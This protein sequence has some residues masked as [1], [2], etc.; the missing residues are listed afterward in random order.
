MIS[1]TAF[2]LSFAKELLLEIDEVK[3]KINNAA[4]L[5]TGS[6]NLEKYSNPFLGVAI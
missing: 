6:D 5:K 4:F 1:F 3:V 2:E